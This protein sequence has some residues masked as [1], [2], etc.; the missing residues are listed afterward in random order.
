MQTESPPSKSAGGE[1][2]PPTGALG[3]KSRKPARVEVPIDATKSH[4]RRLGT[5]A[6][7]GYGDDHLAA[8]GGEHDPPIGA[9]GKW[10]RKQ[11][12]GNRKPGNV[13]R[14]ARA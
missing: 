11:K 9:L 14:D 6:L 3:E 12:A 8:A 4:A 13:S 2:D 10:S 5:A 7:Q 1:H